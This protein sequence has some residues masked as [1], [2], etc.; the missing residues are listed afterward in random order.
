[1]IES[2]LKTLVKEFTTENTVAITLTGSYARG[3]A[4]PYSDLD[5]IHYVRQRPAGQEAYTLRYVDGVLV[6]LTTL[7]LD[8][9][10]ADLT[11]PEAV[12]WCVAG[13]QQARVLV[14]PEDDFAGL[15]AEANAVEWDTAMQE[16]VNAY[17]GAELAGYAEEAH[18][19]LSGLY[20]DDESQTLYG[21]YGLVLGV[22]KIISTQRGLVIPTE[23]AYFQRLQDT[24]GVDS[25]W[26][27]FFRVAAGLDE[28]T[29]RMRGLAA[30]RLYVET[31]RLL[32]D[33]F[34]PEHRAVIAQTVRV[35]NQ[36]QFVASM[37]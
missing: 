21:V 2:L 10:R 11:R 13:L 4:T 34:S 15:Q 36:S 14:D 5:I 31:T 7:T 9:R 8:E 23:N 19:I 25:R 35:I 28:G 29:V 6:S 3:D 18:K 37:L 27:A 12:W 22:A 17:A 33:V 20:H 1:M 32:D 26:T 24:M 16:K 30:L